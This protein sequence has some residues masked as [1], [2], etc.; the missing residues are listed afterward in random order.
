MSDFFTR[1][2]LEQIRNSREYIDGYLHGTHAE[3][4][5]DLNSDLNH[6]FSAVRRIIHGNPS[7]V[8]NWYDQVP[9]SLTELN[10]DVIALSGQIVD[11]DDT[12]TDVFNRGSGILDASAHDFDVT[13]GASTSWYMRDSTNASVYEV[14]DSDNFVRRLGRRHRLKLSSNV[15]KG[16]T[17]TLPTSYT[18]DSEFRNLQIYRNGLLMIPGSGISNSDEEYGH[19]RELNSTQVISPSIGGLTITTCDRTVH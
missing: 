17:L 15:P 10:N 13:L 8:G 1:V 6:I 11:G 16:G 7:G 9:K 3:S 5:V 2:E 14:N 19:Y 12:L 18:L 4:G